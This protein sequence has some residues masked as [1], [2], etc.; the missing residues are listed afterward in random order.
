MKFRIHT[1]GGCAE[2]LNE[3]CVLYRQDSNEYCLSKTQVSF[4]LRYDRSQPVIAQE[5]KYLD[6][7]SKDKIYLKLFFLK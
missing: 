6:E 7:F 5:L 1:R 3:T 2:I 4:K